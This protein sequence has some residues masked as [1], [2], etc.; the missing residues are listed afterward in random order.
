MI[1]ALSPRTYSAH[2]VNLGNST[3]HREIATALRH[4]GRRFRSGPVSPAALEQA[5]SV[6][7]SAGRSWTGDLDGPL[8]EVLR[9]TTAELPVV[10][11]LLPECDSD[12]REFE[13]RLDIPCSIVDLR[14]GIHRDVLFHAADSLPAGSDA[15][16]AA[17]IAS[18]DAIAGQFADVWFPHPPKQA[19]EKLLALLPKRAAILD[20]GCGPGHHSRY[21][22]ARGY[23][24]TGID[25]SC[26]MLNIAR[27]SVFS[28]PFVQMDM[29]RLGSGTKFDAVWCAGAAIHIPRERLPALLAGFRGALA[30]KGVLGLNLQVGRRSEVALLDN[31]RRFFEYY[32]GAAEIA[33]ILKR[34]GF[35][36]IAE[37]YGE[38]RRNTHGAPIVLRWQTMYARPRFGRGQEPEV[39]NDARLCL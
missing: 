17:T 6:V 23:R 3:V 14:W 22:A 36:V 20:A 11:F 25:L 32:S 21:F 29:E 26:A 12:P 18:Y 2:L 13:A 15:V 28:V 37:D 30:D 39:H 31:D 10:A 38:T 1:A 24:V 9:C 33:R 27:R 19:L 7:I 4:R 5:L 35:D 16:K 34:A 8:R